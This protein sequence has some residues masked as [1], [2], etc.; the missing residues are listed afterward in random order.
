MFTDQTL[1][2]K[3]TTAH[4]QPPLQLS[5]FTA[6]G[7]GALP[8]LGGGESALVS[9]SGTVGSVLCP[10]LQRI[11]SYCD[12]TSPIFLALY[13]LI[14]VLECLLKLAAGQSAISLLTWFSGDSTLMYLHNWSNVF[15]VAYS[16]ISWTLDGSKKT[17]Q[18]LWK[19]LRILSLVW[20]RFEH[21]EL[22]KFILG[23]LH[24]LVDQ[25]LG[26]NTNYSWFIRL[27]DSGWFRSNKVW[28][29]SATQ[30]AT[31]IGQHVQCVIVIKNEFVAQNSSVRC[32]YIIFQINL[33]RWIYPLC[34]MW[35]E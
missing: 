30:I 31:D 29:E 15:M 11:I 7:F 2:T 28:E 18:K 20:T 13:R 26:S 16:K 24:C 27:L 14:G 34:I 35:Y 32:K 6:T 9:L 4:T 5:S 3:T 22:R 25:R 19:V 23:E 12:F 21:Y 1:F 10:I 8:A 33:R 17:F